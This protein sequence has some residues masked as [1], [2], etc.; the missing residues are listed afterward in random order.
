MRMDTETRTETRV[1]T[2]AAV[3]HYDMHMTATLL[4]TLL[5]PVLDADRLIGF[6]HVRD[7]Q[8]WIDLRE[9]QTFRILGGQKKN[10]QETHTAFHMV[11]YCFHIITILSPYRIL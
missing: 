9:K 1:H 5:A 7:L 4:P 11:A 10:R 2:E 3:R 8:I 6:H